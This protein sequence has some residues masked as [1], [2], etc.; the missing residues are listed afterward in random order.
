MEQ[1][2]TSTLAKISTLDDIPEREPARIEASRT[3]F[4]AAARSLRPTV[5]KPAK[6]RLM[7]WTKV[8]KKERSPMFTLARIVLL[9]VFALGGTG[10]TAY[11]AQDSLPN[12]A[13]YP[14]KTWIEDL[15]L[16]LTQDP[17]THFDL[18]V[19]FV[20]ERIGEI[21]ALVEDGLSVPNQVATRLNTHLQQMTGVVADMDDPAL[22]KAM[23]QV[24]VRSQVQLQR[25]EKLH[26]NA[27]DDS[28]A[29]GLAT[30]AMHNM[31]NIAGDAL[32]DPLSFRQRQG[33]NRPVDAP[34]IPDN[35]IPNGSGEGSPNGEGQGPGGPQGPNKK[36][37]SGQ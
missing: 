30:Q 20:E 24:Q 8:F 23:E 6:A 27:P 7:G 2:Y 36:N 11:A 14:V 35:D 26:E 5:S 19:G 15:R 9:A 13:L 22:L 16:D 29:L 33:T 17:H 31:R 12:E 1:E 10:V 25:L 32:Q 21:E 4:L 34:E 18:L 28:Q 3:E 37:G